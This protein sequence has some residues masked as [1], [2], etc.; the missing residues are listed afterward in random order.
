VVG[1]AVTRGSGWCARDSSDA[2]GEGRI[3]KFATLEGLRWGGYKGPNG[4]ATV[5][6][7]ATGLRGVYAIGAGGVYELN[8]KV[9]SAPNDVAA[10]RGAP[11]EG[12]TKPHVDDASIT[13]VAP[14]IFSQP[15]REREPWAGQMRR[16][17]GIGGAESGADR[18]ALMK[19]RF[20][21][22]SE[23]KRRVVTVFVS[24]TFTGT[25]PP[26]P[27]HPPPLFWHA[28]HWTG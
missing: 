21:A 3:E 23:A 11:D 9:K 27:P 1:G 6:W 18:N 19:G 28:A 12:D 15:R 13:I 24:S 17:G 2:R 20:D 16:G 8:Y 4:F 14:L 10:E 25:P 26:S 22:V 5:R 7:D